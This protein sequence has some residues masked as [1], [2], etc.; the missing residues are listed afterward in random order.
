VNSAAIQQVVVAMKNEVEKLREQ[1][2]NL[3]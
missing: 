1:V 2:Q 3:E